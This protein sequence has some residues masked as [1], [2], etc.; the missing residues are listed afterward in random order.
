MRS[1]VTAAFRRRYDELPKSARDA[2]W[3][4]FLRFK[5]N[6]RHPG[7]QFKRISGKEPIVSAR[8]SDD[9]GVLGLA[10]D[11][12]IT[13]FWIGPHHEYDKLLKRL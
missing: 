6:P 7:L 5:Q 12:E 3:R 8:V 4:A 13:W 2:A 10:S 9:Y 1:R 11:D